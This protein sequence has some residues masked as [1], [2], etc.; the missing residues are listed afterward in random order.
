MD[1]C[2]AAQ[3][4][5]CGDVPRTHIKISPPGMKGLG[6]KV[7]QYHWWYCWYKDLRLQALLGSA[8]AIKA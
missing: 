6:E 8:T 3:C 2:D 5:R 7:E 1:W 4:R